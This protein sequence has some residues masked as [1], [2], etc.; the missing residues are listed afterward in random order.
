[1]IERQIPNS[2]L[3]IM[4]EEV[5][6]V[7]ELKTK[8]FIA[9]NTGKRISKNYGY[10]YISNEKHIICMQNFGNLSNEKIDVYDLNGNI[11]FENY[12]KWSHVGLSPGTISDIINEYG[13]QIKHKYRIITSRKICYSGIDS[14]NSINLIDDNLNI[15]YK[16]VKSDYSPP[17]MDIYGNLFVNINKKNT[18][19]NIVSGKINHTLNV[20]DYFGYDKYENIGYYI[21]ENNDKTFSIINAFNKKIELEHIK[22]FIICREIVEY[23]SVEMISYITNKQIHSYL[24]FNDVDDI[25]RKRK[26]DINNPD[27]TNIKKLGINIDKLKELLDNHIKYLSI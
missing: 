17:P 26:I 23:S 11:K 25:P 27:K 13:P 1:M 20:I 16:D 7:D 14:N 15:L 10:I 9:D 18:L 4:K 5:V 8:Y 12:K 22:K 2:Q 6:N 19:I 3:F 21:I 24:L